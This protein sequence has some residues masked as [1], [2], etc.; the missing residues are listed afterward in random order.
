MRKKGSDRKQK[1]RERESKGEL[2]GGGRERERDGNNYLKKHLLQTFPWDIHPLQKS[3]Q[4]P[5]HPI[6]LLLP[7]PQLNT[8]LVCT[9]MRFDKPLPV[10]VI[11]HTEGV[12][13]KGNVGGTEEPEIMPSG[14]VY[15]R[16][17][18][19]A[20]ININRASQGMGD[21]NRI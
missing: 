16:R 4:R 20:R 1:D 3:L 12:W 19:S 5:P 2:L 7:H 21:F 10:K 11:T 9:S 18:N 13:E 17:E 14:C 8:A 15:V 6:P